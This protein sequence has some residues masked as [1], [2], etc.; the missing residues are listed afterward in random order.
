MIEKG[1]RYENAKSFAPDEDGNPPFRGIRARAIGPAQP[2]LEHY[3]RIGERHDLLA[4][5]YYNEPRLWWRILDANPGVLSAGE[6]GERGAT[7]P[8]DPLL[9]PAA[10]EPGAR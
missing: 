9:V 6:V 4:A 10:R 1:S 2:V 8:S 5:H 3:P 7:D